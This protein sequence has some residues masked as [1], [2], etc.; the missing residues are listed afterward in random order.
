MDKNRGRSDKSVIWLIL[1]FMVLGLAL[2]TVNDVS[3][4]LMAGVQAYTVGEGHWARAQKLATISLVKYLTTEDEQFYEMF[5]QNIDV[6]NGHRQSR[7]ELASNVPNYDLVEEGFL[8]GMH[9]PE[10]IPKLIWMYEKLTYYSPFQRAVNYWIEGDVL[11][12]YMSDAGDNIHRAIEADNLNEAAISHLTDHIFYLDRQ[13]TRAETNFSLAITEAADWLY[14]RVI[15]AN[16]IAI[17]I[18]LLGGLVFAVA[19]VEILRQWGEDLYYSEKKFREVLSY[20]R[21]VIYQLDIR[22]GE[23]IY[24]SPSVEKVFGYTSDEL[25]KGGLSFVL[26]LTHPDDLKRMK[27]EVIRYSNGDVDKL[28]SK[29]SEFRLKT[30]HGG[31]I[32]VSNKRS[33]LRDSSGNPAAII[34]NVRDISERKVYIESLDASLKEKEMLLSEIHHRVKNNL[35]IVSSLI[36]LQ[37]NSADNGSNKGLQEIQL[38]IK[39]IALVHEKLYQNETFADVDLAE[40][41]ED[42]VETVYTTFNSDEKKISLKKNMDSLSVN[43]K[44]AVPIGLI[45]NEMLNNCYKYA[46][47]GIDEG[48]ITVSLEVKG[49]TATLIVSDNGIGLPEEF[50]E[51]KKKSLGMTLIEVFT[52]QIDGELTY[53]SNNGSHFSVSFEI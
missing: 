27:A 39:S 15:W 37:K 11:I 30:K 5:Y 32:W 28:L 36:E 19:R 53:E 13:L 9:R 34:G 16:R 29:D 49:N 42:L 14:I 23:Y 1:L 43:I 17:I 22:T 40:Y 24:I 46:F 41:I 52:K 45:C 51:M 18:V 21:D 7:S 10:D 31:Y 50:E 12:A 26:S 44:R 4:R 47:E 20:S 48:V 35:S 2:I 38:R 3:Y 6:I 25:I 33:V 8:R